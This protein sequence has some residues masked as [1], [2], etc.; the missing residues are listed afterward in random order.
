MK[1]E[2]LINIVFL[3]AINLLIKPF[4]IFGIDRTVQNTVGTD[5][6]GLY[7]ALFGA[8][9]LW[10]IVNDFGI[11][12]FNNRFIS[13][14]R[15]LVSKYLPD[16]LILKGLLSVRYMAILL[17]WAWLAGHGALALHLLCFIGLTQVLASLY[18]HLM[19]LSYESIFI[20]S[21]FSSKVYVYY[22]SFW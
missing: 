4:Y 20:S 18:D 6:Y 10:Q 8:A 5:L 15:H 7:F 17:T 1:R 11:Q 21:W 13:Q 19:T 3:I 12:N 2:F 16:V 9:L 22:K 14:H